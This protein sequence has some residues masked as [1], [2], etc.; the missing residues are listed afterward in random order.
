M[1]RPVSSTFGLQSGSRRD[2][3]RPCNAWSSENDD[4]YAVGINRQVT[5][6][7][8]IMWRMALE[9]EPGTLGWW[10][11]DRRAELDMTWNE[12]AE[13]AGLGK[14]TLFRAIQGRPMRTRTKKAIERALQWQSG[15]IDAIRRGGRPA[16][17][18]EDIQPDL[19]VPFE[20]NVWHDTRLTHD[21]KTAF[22]RE[23]RR[24][25]SGHAQSQD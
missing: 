12:L 24:R 6:G 14:E 2:L 21:D 23:Y 9:H 18:V 15:S 16:N 11:D 4:S 10:V 22:I 25:V 19:S 17:L 8:V 5:F 20:A 1:F 3:T 7:H 13:R